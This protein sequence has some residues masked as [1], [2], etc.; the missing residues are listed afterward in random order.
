MLLSPRPN[1]HYKELRTTKD[2]LNPK[3]PRH[4]TKAT[5]QIIE[6]YCSRSRPGSFFHPSQQGSRKKLHSTLPGISSTLCV[7][8]HCTHS[9]PCY[10]FSAGRVWENM[11]RRIR[12]RI[13]K[14][15]KHVSFF[16]HFGRAR[17]CVCVCGMRKALFPMQRK[18]SLS[19]NTL[20]LPE[21]RWDAPW[22]WRH[23]KSLRSS[24]RFSE[25]G[26]QQWTPT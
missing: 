17:V 6:I 8:P 19:E 2:K 15:G 5:T 12:R 13:I 14:A 3:L 21:M 9:Q 23:L 7:R 11:A 18:I 1:P 24:S 16:S 20:R 22:I 26:L 4:T 25:P 10:F